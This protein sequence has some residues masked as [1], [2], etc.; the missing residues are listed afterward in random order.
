MAD[1][2]QADAV[3]EAHDTDK[4]LLEVTSTFVPGVPDYASMPQLLP[5]GS[6]FSQ[7]RDSEVRIRHTT[8]SEPS[9]EASPG[10]EHRRTVWALSHEPGNASCA[11]CRALAPTWASASQGGFICTQCA[12]APL[13]REK[14][15]V[16]HA[17]AGGLPF[18][19]QACIVR[20]GCTSPLC[21][22]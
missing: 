16:R 2:A 21:S 3:M 19:T 7:D 1:F 15:L 12:G 4:V 17:L 13:H 5:A 6:G 22:P 20:S 14:W 11:D 10:D 18:A 8:G 9:E